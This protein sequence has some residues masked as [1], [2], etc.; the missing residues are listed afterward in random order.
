M[1]GE[2]EFLGTRIKDVCGELRGMLGLKMASGEMKGDYEGL[3]I[4]MKL[5]DLTE[6]CADQLH[7]IDDLITLEKD[8]NAK[9]KLLS[10]KMDVLIKQK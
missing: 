10:E 6:D 7:K 3:M 4:V 2:Y 5:L 8:N 1:T 9:L